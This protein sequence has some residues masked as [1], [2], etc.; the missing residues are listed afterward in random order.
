VG[1]DGS[2]YN[3]RVRVV[4]LLALAACGRVD[5]AE[6]TLDAAAD[7]VVATG[8][9]E[10]GDGIPDSQDPCPHVAGT[11]LDSDNDGVGDDCDPNPTTPTEHWVKF[12]TMQTGDIAFDD[13]SGFVQEA[14]SIRAPSDAAPYITL[15]VTKVRI[16]MGWT[17]H[18]VVGTG[19]HQVA[20]GVDENTGTPEYYF[21]ELN[22]AIGG[23]HD[24][25]IYQYDSS[26]YTL[27]DGI[28]PGA[29]HAGDGLM[30][31]DCDTTH[32]LF[33]GWTGQMYTVTAATPAYAGGKGIR[34]AFNGI[35]VS[36]NYL[37]I[38]ATN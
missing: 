9:D 30:R 27:L 23:T 19:Q 38:I 14:D 13:I 24:A 20:F 2:G 26:G 5:F 36:I 25:A 7:G 37:A 4:V 12:A 8:H 28:D 6:R 1:R 35:D 18:A 15:P 16:D 3:D 34:F 22:Q 29:F 31:M 10:D 11:T 32:H 33:T 21:A 17:V